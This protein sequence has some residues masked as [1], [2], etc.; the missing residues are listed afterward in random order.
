MKQDLGVTSKWR[1]DQAKASVLKI[2]DG[3]K[4]ALNRR[5]ELYYGD[6]TAIEKIADGIDK[7]NTARQIQEFAE[8]SR[9][10]NKG[11]NDMAFRENVVSISG[12]DKYEVILSNSVVCGVC[13]DYIYSAHQH[14][15]VQC[16]CGNIAVDGGTSYIRRL[17]G[18]K[19]YADTS[20]IVSRKEYDQAVANIKW[21]VTNGRNMLGLVSA[22]A[23]GLNGH[24]S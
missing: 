5:R 18:E 11:D 15:F 10:L 3:L 4:T 19:G 9:E 13:D 7:R 6:K 23:R 20:I 16:S 2:V 12:I 14:D 17:G 1:R 22:M 21:A 8:A 24:P